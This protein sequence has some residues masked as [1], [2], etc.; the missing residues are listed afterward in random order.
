MSTPPG[1]DARIRKARGFMR[2]LIDLAELQEWSFR[3]QGEGL[4]FFPPEHARRPGFESVYMSDCGNDSGTQRKIRDR[5]R[6]AGLKFPEDEPPKRTATVTTPPKFTLVQPAPTETSAADPFVL[7]RQKVDAALNLM[8]EIVDLV[9]RV[10]ADNA[11]FKALK[12]MLKGL[13]Q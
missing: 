1:V 7:I 6:K 4:L 3:V 10:E 13:G 9:G 12:D 2:E 11:K 5:F 8:T